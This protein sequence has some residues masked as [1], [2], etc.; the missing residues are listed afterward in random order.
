MNA[1][2]FYEEFK[3]CLQFL[4]LSWGNKGLATVSIKDGCVVVSHLG[5]QA[6]FSLEEK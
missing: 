2:Q 3:S 5:R 1:E 6:M 4:D